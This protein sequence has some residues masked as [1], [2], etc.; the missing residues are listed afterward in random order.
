MRDDKVSVG[1]DVQVS[2]TEDPAVLR[3]IAEHPDGVR[4]NEE[5][6]GVGPI[7]DHIVPVVGRHCDTSR[8]G[9]LE[10]RHESARIKTPECDPVPVWMCCHDCSRWVMESHAQ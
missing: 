7:G 9:Q 5:E 10:L 6:A 8:L 2:A 4:L 1:P 3:S